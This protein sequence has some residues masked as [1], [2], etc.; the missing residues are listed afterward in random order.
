[1][2]ILDSCFTFELVIHNGREMYEHVTGMTGKYRP[3]S[4][5]EKT[6]AGGGYYLV[7]C[8]LLLILQCV[9]W[10]FY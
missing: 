3:C 4:N 8:V 2:G 10:D 7:L 9:R 1:M 6:Y 5:C